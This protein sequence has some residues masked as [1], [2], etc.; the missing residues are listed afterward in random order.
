M[1]TDRNYFIHKNYAHRG[2]HNLKKGIPENSLAA[3]KAAVDAG[4]GVELDVQLT[5]DGQVVVMHDLN[6]KRACGIDDLVENYDYDELRKMKIFNT[7]ETIPLF[8]DVLKVLEEKPADLVCE[9]KP[10]VRIGELCEKT[11][12]ILKTYKGNFCVESFDPRITHWFKTHAPEVVRG[13]LSESFDEWKKMPGFVKDILSNCKL[14]TYCK[15][16]FVAYENKKRPKEVI[17]KCKDRN[18]LLFGWVSREPDVDQAQN[19]A[20][21]FENYLPAPTYK[22]ASS[23]R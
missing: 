19:D 4:Y 22:Q 11:W 21:I 14:L 5:K 18:I 13:L 20:V 23:G 1:M 3:F 8:S 17:Q 2:L 12:E 15:P 7:D 10:R 16:D 6:L 9:I